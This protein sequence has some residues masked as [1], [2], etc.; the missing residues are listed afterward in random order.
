MANI[1]VTMKIMPTS[2]ES[3]LENIKTES[4]KEIEIFAGSGEVKTI[5]EPIAFG[6]KALK[7]LF[8]MDENIGSTDKL[9]TK[10][11]GFNDVNSVEIVDVR[12]T[13]G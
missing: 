13:I 3:D 9:E 7:I 4:I 8:V 5:V 12:R 2:P 6:L 1:V 10:I 11:N